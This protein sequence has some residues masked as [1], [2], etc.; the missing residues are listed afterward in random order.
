MNSTVPADRYFTAFARSTAC[1]P[2]AARVRASRNGDGASSI[3]F[4][5]RRWIEHSR[6]KRYSVLPCASANTWISIWRGCSM[7]FSMKTRSS[8]K[9]DFAS[10]CVAFSPSRTSSAERAIR[11]PLPPPPADAL[12]MTG[13]P[14]SVATVTASSTS[15]MASGDPGTVLTFASFA[16]RLL[17]I[18]SPM[19]AMASGPGPMKA[20]LAASR[21]RQNAGFSETKP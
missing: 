9:L 6:S 14:I 20:I 18:L 12:S 1:F 19:A 21:A 13:K 11:I 17:A 7:N 16:S 3:T 4:W 2:I 8:P 10:D 5:W 15:L